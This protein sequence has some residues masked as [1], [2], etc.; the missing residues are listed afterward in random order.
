M[1]ELADGW[2]RSIEQQ[3]HGW[4]VRYQ[5]ANERGN[6]VLTIMAFADGIRIFG[7]GGIALQT[8]Q[9]ARALERVI[10]LAHRQFAQRLERG[11]DP[12]TSEEDKREYYRLRMS[13]G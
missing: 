7:E 11:K 5:L 2:K 6:P 3:V 8:E 12:F 9:Q 1:S 13:L 10:C 4:Q